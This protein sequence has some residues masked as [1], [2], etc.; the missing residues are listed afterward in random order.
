M[1]KAKWE[2]TAKLL[3][4]QGAMKQNIDVS[5]AFTDKFLTAA[6]PLKR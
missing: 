2:S 6:S 5:A 3:V 4:E 1:T